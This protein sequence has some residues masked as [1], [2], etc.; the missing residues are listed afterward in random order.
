VW[1]LSACA[2]SKQNVPIDEPLAE[3]EP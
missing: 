2:E 3:E 1:S